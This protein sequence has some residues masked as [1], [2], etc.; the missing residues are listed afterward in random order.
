MPRKMQHQKRKPGRPKKA[1]VVTKWI[2]TTDCQP[3]EVPIAEQLER[4]RAAR[5]G[6]QRQLDD[7][8]REL[9]FANHLLATI[10]AAVATP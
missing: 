2:H 8:R 7:T 3:A 10:R 4:C 1:E 6:L 9:S 5:D